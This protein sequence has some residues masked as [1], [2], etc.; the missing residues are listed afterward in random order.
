MYFP[1]SVLVT[2]LATGGVSGFSPLA[3]PHFLGYS[4]LAA[5]VGLATPSTKPEV[6]FQSR[7]AEPKD[8]ES[9]PAAAFLLSKEFPDESFVIQYRSNSGYLMDDEETGPILDLSVLKQINVDDDGGS[10]KVDAGVTV[11]ALASELSQLEDRSLFHLKEL[12]TVLPADSMMSVVEAALDEKYDKLRE[13][14]KELHV[15]DLDGI[16]SSKKLS[17]I[18]EQ[19]E[20]IV[21]I[22]LSPEVQLQKVSALESTKVRARWYTRIP[23]APPIEK[24]LVSDI[25]DDVKV[26]VFKYGMFNDNPT[27]V[28]FVD[29]DKDIGLSA[30]EW[31]ET[32][33]ETP[34]K[35]WRLQNELS[36]EAC[37]EVLTASG[38]L[39]I[40]ASKIDVAFTDILDVFLDRREHLLV[41]IEKDKISASFDAKYPPDVDEATSKL[42]TFDDKAPRRIAMAA[43]SKP[44]VRMRALEKVVEPKLTRGTVIEGFKG[45]IFDGVRGQMQDKRFQY[46]T[47]SYDNMMNPSLIVYPLDEE[48]VALAVKFA[49]LDEYA[50]AR[51][52]LAR[53]SGNKY[54]VIGR[55]GGHQYCGVSCDNDALIVSMDKFKKLEHYD[56]NLEC[57]TGPDGE[58]HTVTHEVHVGTGVRLKQFAE[59]M[60]KDPKTNLP[61]TGSTKKGKDS[62]GVT[63]PHGECPTVGIG[64]HSQTGGYGH[65]LRNFGLAIDYVYGFDIVT[66]NGEFR[67]N[68]NRDSTCEKD[69]EL[70]WAVLGG[71]PGAFGIT[72]KLI[73]HPILDKDYPHS[74]GWSRTYLHTNC[75]MEAILK[76]LEDFI[77]RANE[78]DDDALAEGLDLM[79]SL[80]SHNDNAPIIGLLKPSLMLAELECRD[81]TD[82]KAYDQMQEIITRFEKEVGSLSLRRTFD[83]KSHYKLSEMSLGYTRKP[84]AVTNTGRENRRAYRKAAYG[85]KDKLKPGWSKAF[86]ALLNDVVATK[87]DIAC[88]FQV[89]V[90]GGA[91]ARFG[92]AN[93]N[94]I[95]H[96]DAQLSNIVFDL[97][98][99]DD[100]ESIKAADAFATRFEL[101]VVNPYQTAYPKV[102]AQWAS[103]GDLEMNKKEVWEKYFDK[104]ET[105]HRLR[106][107]KKDV[108]PDDVFHSRFTVRPEE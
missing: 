1:L 97:F 3:P 98:R 21:N 10:I 2:L 48:D 96:R 88:I 17:E 16:I 50:E 56:V 68:V 91:Q 44:L 64:G 27:I 59:F 107:I 67:K 14:V 36:K 54:K 29:G 66:A 62:F 35:F 70:Y 77:N 43:R 25:P 90:G 26:M 94:S 87:A 4:H 47:S 42:F 13:A 12:F 78:S 49:T 103:H 24:G 76:I 5:S 102:M 84:P 40:D 19:Q 31:D 92:K 37:F 53:P 99:G 106:A 104:P 69:K 108:D 85:S 100:D 81:M 20:I 30:D 45:E 89:G 65:I 51:K 105:Y 93:L 28:V 7:I 34:E 58:P 82:K 33:V 60:N 79:V 95:A 86:A 57:V 52:T 18:D 46:A 38:V 80:S 15:V 41:T 73:F 22:V 75:G 32:L 23:T 61:A 11:G 39:D 83:G 6:F 55:G 101:E 74:T 72:T 9:V 63:I 8:I 71:S